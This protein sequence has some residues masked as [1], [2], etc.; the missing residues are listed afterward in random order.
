MKFVKC[1]L[2]RSYFWDLIFYFPLFLQTPFLIPGSFLSSLPSSWPVI[3]KADGAVRCSLTNERIAWHM[4]C[5]W[6]SKLKHLSTVL[7]QRRPV[8]HRW[9]CFQ[10]FFL[11]SCLHSSFPSHL[12][13]LAQHADVHYCPPRQKSASTPKTN[14][15]TR[16]HPLMSVM[17][18][19]DR[20]LDR[21]VPA[22]SHWFSFLSL[23]EF[24]LFCQNKMERCK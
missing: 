21:R 18:L 20:Q 16:A 5:Y 10:A 4:L 14:T 17:A 1:G 15:I 23:V 2:F 7:E 9:S 24:V 22:G 11:S 3:W 19:C 12:L 6:V 8:S 13:F